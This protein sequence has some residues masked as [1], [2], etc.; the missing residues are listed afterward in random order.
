MYLKVKRL[1]SCL[2]IITSSTSFVNFQGIVH[3]HLQLLGQVLLFLKYVQLLFGIATDV[4]AFRGWLAP[5]G[6][7]V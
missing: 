2:R 5:G 1:A 4:Y 3:L 7:G 6:C